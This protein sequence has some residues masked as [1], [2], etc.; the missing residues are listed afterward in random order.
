MK[1]LIEFGITFLALF[2]FFYLVIV[3]R[4]KKHKK[5][6]DSY[7]NEVLALINIY[8]LD[9]KKVEYKKL[10]WLY[11][12]VLT[13][14]FSLLVSLIVL[15]KKVWLML[16]VGLPLFFIVFYLVYYLLKV[17]FSKKGWVKHE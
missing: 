9:M 2:I 1:L 15:L 3:Y 16:L 4:G 7:T 10:L 17:Y 12:I 11:A 5:K 8:K 14:A 13:I 6:D